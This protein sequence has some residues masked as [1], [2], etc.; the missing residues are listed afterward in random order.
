M[1]KVGKRFGIDESLYTI[2]IR[3][4]Q[5]D[6]CFDIRTIKTFFLNFLPSEG[7]IIDNLFLSAQKETHLEGKF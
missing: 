5:L 2:Y 3:C 1:L 4:I 7:I 6:V